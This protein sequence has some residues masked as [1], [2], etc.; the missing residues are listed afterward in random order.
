MKWTVALLDKQYIIE[1]ADT[2]YLAKKEAAE[3]YIK[4]E[5]ANLN[6]TML[7]SIARAK[8]HEDRRVKFQYTKTIP[9][10][11]QIEQ[12]RREALGMSND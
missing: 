12:E 6:T 5:K 8:C 3:R 7:V 2:V 9:D 10:I 4:E 1:N 11:L